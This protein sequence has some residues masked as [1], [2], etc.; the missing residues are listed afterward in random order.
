[1]DVV[2][3]KRLDSL[4]SNW[5][6]R[7]SDLSVAAAVLAFS[8][9]NV[10]RRIARAA[11]REIQ[12]TYRGDLWGYNGP[13]VITR[14]LKRLCSTTDVT[15]MSSDLCGGFEVY[16]PE[17]FYPIKWENAR[18]YF[19]RGQ[20]INKGAYVYHVWNHLTANLVADHDSPYATLARQFCPTTYE[21]YGERFGT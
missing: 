4:G 14:V 8:T 12:T 18:D 2:V 21:M 6:A 1:M 13:G 15:L 19:K 11:V 5:A 17:L 3:A 7:E 10:G 20:L 9:D 16:G